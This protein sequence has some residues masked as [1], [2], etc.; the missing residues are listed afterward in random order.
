MPTSLPSSSIKTPQITSNQTFI[1]H[2]TYQQL[3]PAP[4]SYMPPQVPMALAPKRDSSGNLKSVPTT[5]AATAT[6]VA[7]ADMESKAKKAKS[8]KDKK[9]KKIVR[10]AGGQVWEDDTLVEWDSGDYLIDNLKMINVFFC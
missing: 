4:S 10:A 7:A 5:A 1:Q 2:Q 6:A 9:K 3:I 8:E